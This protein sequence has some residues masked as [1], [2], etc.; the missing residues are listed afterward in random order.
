M[1]DEEEESQ[2]DKLKNAYRQRLQQMQLDAQKKELLKKMMVPS[3]YERMMNVRLSNPE[4][5]EKV[6]SSLAYVAQ[7]G[8]KMAIISDEQLYD[9]L[10]K[11][12][13]KEETKIE[14]R[15]K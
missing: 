11:M 4:L 10:V 1:A 2:Q 9:L 5:Y 3:A 14:F 6:V 7:S 12:T 15:K 13:H 8:R